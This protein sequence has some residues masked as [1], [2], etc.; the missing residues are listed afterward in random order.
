[1]ETLTDQNDVHVILSDQSSE[2]SAAKTLDADHDMA[3]KL[4]MQEA[5][6]ASLALNPSSEY[7]RLFSRDGASSSGKAMAETEC[8]SVYCKGLISEEVVKNVKMAVGGIGVAICDRRDNVVF[9]SKKNLEAVVDGER[10]SN[11]AAEFEALNE[12]LNKA[13][14][15]KLKNVEF[16][17]DDSKLYQYVSLSIK[18]FFDCSFTILGAI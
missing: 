18:Y 2:L 14:A 1:M 15:L 4:Q 7:E 12:G 3:F 5:M 17:F 9:E 10:L 13:L 8:F 11:E 16:Y 6:A